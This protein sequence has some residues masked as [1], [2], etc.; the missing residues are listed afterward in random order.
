[1]A[2][3]LLLVSICASALFVD[4]MEPRIPDVTTG[5]LWWMDRLP[6]PALACVARALLWIPRVALIP[7]FMS[8]VGLFIQFQLE[9]QNRLDNESRVRKP[10]FQFQIELPK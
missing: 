6:E 10:K 3:T 8:N 4:N 1:M 7:D 2:E 5:V 9:L